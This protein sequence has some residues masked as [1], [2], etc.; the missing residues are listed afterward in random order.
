MYKVSDTTGYTYD[1]R[2]YFGKDAHTATKE[3]TATYVTVRNLTRRVE[4][5]SQHWPGKGNIQ[6]NHCLLSAWSA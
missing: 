3:M 6:R 5:D 4:G 1:M 2:V